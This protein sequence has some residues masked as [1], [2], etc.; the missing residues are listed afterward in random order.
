[1]NLRH[2]LFGVE[3]DAICMLQAVQQVF[4]WIENP[5]N[6]C[7]FVVT[8]NVDHT[9]LLSE[10]ENLRSAYDDAGLVF[11][12]RYGAHADDGTGNGKVSGRWCHGV[13]F[14]QTG[15]RFRGNF[16]GDRGA[17]CRCDRVFGRDYFDPVAETGRVVARRG[18]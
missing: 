3:I 1:M 9:V 7:Q 8:P 17:G 13:E 15:A 18:E 11:L 14:A 2:Q 10:N 6:H 16:R 4:E 12:A 5:G